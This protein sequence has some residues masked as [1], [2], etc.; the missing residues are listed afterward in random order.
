M[1]RIGKKL[2]RKAKRQAIRQQRSEIKDA[3]KTYREGKKS[4]RQA[5]KRFKAG[6]YEYINSS[7]FKAFKAEGKD[8]KKKRYTKS[9]RRNKRNKKIHR[10]LNNGTSTT[11]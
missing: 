3:R 6:Q 8:L 11:K 2:L 5:V 9:Q 4:G 7:E 1:S 10:Y